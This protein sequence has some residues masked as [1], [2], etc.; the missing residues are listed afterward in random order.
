MNKH[1]EEELL[2]ITQAMME[3]LN[4]PTLTL[5]QEEK[6]EVTLITESMFFFMDSGE[7]DRAISE[8]RKI[9]NILSPF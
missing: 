6:D 1:Q 2:E 8:G 5:S 9:L 7:A 4:K 3:E